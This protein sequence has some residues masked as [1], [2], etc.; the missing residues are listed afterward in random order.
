MPRGKALACA[1][2][3][4]RPR[5]PLV[6][7]RRPRSSQQARHPGNSRAWGCNPAARSTA[8]GRN[9]SV[10]PLGE[11][12][13]ALALACASG[14]LLEIGMSRCRRCQSQVSSPGIGGNAVSIDQTQRLRCVAGAT[15]SIASTCAAS[16]ATVLPQTCRSLTAIRSL[17]AF[18]TSQDTDAVQASAG[19]CLL[20]QLCCTYQGHCTVPVSRTTACA[21]SKFY[22][23]LRR[24]PQCLPFSRVHEPCCRS[25]L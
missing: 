9:K 19:A 15:C 13:L 2:C 12:T 25:C 21:V 24:P 22:M 23:S 3:C 20:A 11:W 6:S 5:L 16:A 1:A 4:D 10:G 14:S 17:Q 7:F 18:R 8:D